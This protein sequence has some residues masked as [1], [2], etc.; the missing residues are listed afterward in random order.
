MTTAKVIY[1][2]APLGG[3][4]AACDAAVAKHLGLPVFKAADCNDFPDGLWEF[5]KS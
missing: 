3:N 1:I 2:A 4:G 5:L